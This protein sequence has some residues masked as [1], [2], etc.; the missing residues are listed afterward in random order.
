MKRIFA[1]IFAVTLALCAA[2]VTT[3]A[4]TQPEPKPSID[5][6]VSIIKV[7]PVMTVEK[8][9]VTDADGDGTISVSDAI[10]CAHE[11]KY[12][13]GAAAGY[14][15]EMTQ[16][17]IS[18]TKLWG[19]SNGGSYGYYV[20]NVSPMS[21]ADEI[22][23]GDHICA[24]IYT[25]TANFSDKYSYFDKLNATVDAGGTLELTLSYADYDETWAPI[26]KLAENATITVDGK[27]TSFTTDKDGKVTI[28]LTEAGTHVISAI[29]KTENLVS[30]V[31]VVT[32]NAPEPTYEPTNY[33]WLI[34]ICAAVVVAATAAAILLS[35]KN[36]TKK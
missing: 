21:L 10:F 6:N 20:N 34:P 31:C 14:A 5:V 28:T 25:D 17:G 32:V 9:T 35:K 18:P 13:G 26:V 27:D 33:G 3:S 22:K 8:V 24:F 23:A 30:P 29:S 12:E 7:F 36:S 15:T 2:T 16:W 1:L 11:K 4:E 19:V